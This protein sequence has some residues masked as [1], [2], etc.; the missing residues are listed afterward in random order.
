MIYMKPVSIVE[1]KDYSLPKVKDALRKSLSDL[2]FSIPTGK[3]ILIKPNVLGGFKPGDAVT[4]HP[5]VI[6]AIIHLF[7]VKNRLYVGDSCGVPDPEGSIGAL[8]KSGIAAAVERNSK[9]YDVHLMSFERTKIEMKKIKGKVLHEIPL[10]SIISEVDMIINVPK[11]KTHSLTLF[12]GAVKNT[13]GC[14]PGGQKSR[15]HAMGHTLER[16]LDMIID[17]H[18]AVLPSLHIMDG[19]LALEGE[20][21]SSSGRPRKIGLILVS[22]N[23]Y[24][25]DYV[26][27]RLCR[28][29]E[30]DML[31]LNEAVRRK[32][33]SWRL[34]RSVRVFGNERKVDLKK[35]MTQKS[36][37]LI[38][39]ILSILMRVFRIDMHRYPSFIDI[40]CIRCGACEKGCPVRAITI[41]GNDLPVV[42]KRKCIGCYCCHEFCKY[43]AITLKNR[44]Y[45][46]ILSKLQS[47][48]KNW[49]K[50]LFR[51][52]F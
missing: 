11:L 51:T 27:Q 14:I 41:V 20:G 3:K 24:S 23:G 8:K 42:D 5:V 9:K 13:F 19:I 40:K 36:V 31:L 2:G 16:F 17:I 32:I 18:E 15:Y 39:R 35:P 38:V 47:G 6:E 1:C 22:E 10:P 4:T 28:F 50:K 21:P 46:V 43:R 12:T 48:I 44:L 29:R 25:L 34:L 7:G 33:V 37:H 26:S 30:E 49:L 52:R 45:A